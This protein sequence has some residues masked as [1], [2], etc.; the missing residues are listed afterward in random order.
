MFKATKELTAELINNRK[1]II[2]MSRKEFANQYAGSAFGIFWGILKPLMMVA[3]YWFV[4]SVIGREP[5]GENTPK[6]TQLAMMLPGLVA[7]NFLSEALLNGSGAIRDNSYLVK[8]VAFPV[9]IL[10]VVKICVSFVHHLIFLGISVIILLTQGIGFHLA[11]LQ[12]F[13]YMFAAVFFLVGITRLLAVFV[14]ITVDVMHFLQTIMQVLFWAT[15][16]LWS[17]YS[18]SSNVSPVIVTLLK[19]NPML[20]IV[21][22]YRDAMLSRAWFWGHPSLGLYFWG[23]SIVLYIFSSWV[24][25]KNRKEFADIL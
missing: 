23:F 15:P 22:G 12:I 10:P 19:L 11:N 13:Y 1:I 16:V 24:Y 9:S 5:I 2:S 4:F 8:K 7:W 18:I 6:Y 21:E 25:V 17:V 3:V 14:V 20:Y